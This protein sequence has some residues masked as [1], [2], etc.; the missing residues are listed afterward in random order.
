MLSQDSKPADASVSRTEFGHTCLADMK[1][2]F[3]TFF[4]ALVVLGSQ[5]SVGSL[6]FA[7]QMDGEIH[8]SCCC[9]GEPDSSQRAEPRH[10]DCDCCD[11]QVVE[12]PLATLVPGS[13]SEAPFSPAM[14]PPHITS[15]SLLSPAS[16]QI[17]PE[18]AL[19][20]YPLPPIFLL[21]SSFLI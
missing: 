2:R 3:F 18:M 21:K 11:V 1:S 13:L 10:A 8:R 4:L 16:V 7:C 6:V 15:R 5:L 17:K 9:K 20:K 14:P 19:L 12:T